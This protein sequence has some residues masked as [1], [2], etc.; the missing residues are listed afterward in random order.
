MTTTV[1]FLAL[2]LLVVLA[3]CTHTTHEVNVQSN[4]RLTLIDSMALTGGVLKVDSTQITFFLPVYYA[5]P[6]ADTI[7]LP[8]G[9]VSP[10]HCT[11]S[12]LSPDGLR[13][14]RFTPKN[15][16]LAIDTTMTLAWRVLDVPPHAYQK[17]FPLIVTNHSDSSIQVGHHNILR[18][19]S[20]EAQAPDGRWVE[21]DEDPTALDFC[22][23]VLQ[24]IVLGPQEICISKVL[25]HTRGVETLC[26]LK[27]HHDFEDYHP[28]PIYSN[29]FRDFV[30][31]VRL[32]R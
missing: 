4:G 16:T 32:G 13:W 19:T 18:W 14:T 29:T 3:S 27:F 28:A 23:A 6:Q 26:R 5:G 12:D 25:L 22:G 21:L 7:K 2:A 8:R 20:R 15:L 31:P 10:T 9:I 11:T 17:A 1:K 24:D 30:D